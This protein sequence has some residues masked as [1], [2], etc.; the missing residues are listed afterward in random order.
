MTKK[1]KLKL[2]KLRKEYKQ[3]CKK[4]DKV[5]S[6]A[7]HEFNNISDPPEPDDWMYAEELARLCHELE[8]LNDKADDLKDSI[9]E[10]LR[11]YQ[12]G[13][14]YEQEEDK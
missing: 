9:D 6:D 10:I 11:R 1:D 2:A 5:Q 12:R 7:S 3:A 14:E 4:Y 8:D 13:F